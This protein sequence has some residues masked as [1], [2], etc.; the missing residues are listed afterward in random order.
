MYLVL[1]ILSL[2]VFGI[3][4]AVSVLFPQFSVDSNNPGC[5][6]PEGCHNVSCHL[7]LYG[8]IDGDD[9]CMKG[10]VI[11]AELIGKDSPNF[12]EKGLESNEEGLE[13]NKEGLE[14][15][16]EGI[17]S[18]EEGIES[19][20]EGLESNEEGLE[21]NIEGIESNK[22]CLESNEEDLEGNKEGFESFGA[23]IGG[24]PPDVLDNLRRTSGSSFE[25][26]DTGPSSASD[27]LSEEGGT[28][29]SPVSD[30]L[31]SVPIGVCDNS[32]SPAPCTASCSF[33]DLL[34]DLPTSVWTAAKYPISKGNV[35]AIFKKSN[36]VKASIYTNARSRQTARRSRDTELLILSNDI[37]A[38]V[39]KNQ[40][41]DLR[42]ALRSDRVVSFQEKTR[43]IVDGITPGDD[44]VVSV[45]T[46]WYV[47]KLLLFRLLINDLP[48]C[49]T[50]KS[51]LFAN[52]CIVYRP[53]KNLK[54]CELLQ[55]D[56]NN[57]SQVTSQ[58]LPAGNNTQC[59][60]F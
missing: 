55:E 17:E 38:S 24:E 60:L 44:T 34:S 3:V 22:E 56:L 4:E 49:I 54:D 50:L 32:E 37:L 13:S 1:G 19:N 43:V 27:G 59:E 8:L 9:G 11:L 7:R 18:N 47:P 52:G 30:G 20:E 14:S 40:A 48:E 6:I 51:R 29:A 12:A 57:P 15:N 45:V 10:G 58:I 26:G 23:T 35:S 5:R 16:E 53:I 41:M 2:G 28:D 21:S 36:H 42:E 25:D 33:C 39:D 46:Q 31:S